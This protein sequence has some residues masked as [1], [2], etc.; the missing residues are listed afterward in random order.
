MIM[1]PLGNILSYIYETT[2]FESS[3]KI[4]LLLSFVGLF[5]GN[6]FFFISFILQ[7]F[8]LLFI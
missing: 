4:Q 1:I 5:L 6:L 7:P 2:W 3:T 8:F